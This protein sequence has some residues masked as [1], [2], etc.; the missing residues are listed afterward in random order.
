[1]RVRFRNGDLGRG[2]WG[3]DDSGISVE[4]ASADSHFVADFVCMG[5]V[6]VARR[7]SGTLRRLCRTARKRRLCRTARRA[8]VFFCPVEWPKFSFVG[9][10]VGGRNL[11][12]CRMNESRPG[13]FRPLFTN[14]LQNNLKKCTAS[15]MLSSRDS[16]TGPHDMMLMHGPCR[17]ADCLGE[18]PEQFTIGPAQPN[19]TR[20]SS[21][22]PFTYVGHHG[23]A[24]FSAQLTMTPPKP[25]YPKP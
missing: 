21:Q 8:Y 16:A 9:V 4:G 20:Q 19:I 12:S 14:T 6:W 5:F 22:S 1:M 2:V 7:H 23:S 17:G 15:A 18:G 11:A 24:I 13:L 3:V 10:R 25:S